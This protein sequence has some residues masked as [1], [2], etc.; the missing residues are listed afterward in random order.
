[1]R[2]D[3][4]S[5]IDSRLSSVR[6]AKKSLHRNSGLRSESILRAS[7][8]CF[9]NDDYEKVTIPLISKSIGVTHSLIYYY[10]KNKETL[11]QAAIL[12]ALYILMSRYRELLLE[13]KD[14]IILISDY[15]DV[16]VEMSDTLRSLV[17]IIFVNAG[18]SKIS[19]PKF[20]DSFIDDFYD[21]EKR[22]LSY[23]VE[24]GVTTGQFSCSNSREFA[25]FISRNIDG[26]YYG[27]FMPHGEPIPIA[28][29]YLKNIVLSLL[30]NDGLNDNARPIARSR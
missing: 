1:M 20:I 4:L 10:F 5:H 2:S 30:I 3:T 19:S 27:S 15:L 29:D 12:H 21:I 24:L 14:P 9:A 8:S 25:N 18:S 11:C 28:M 16:N 22:I 13:E 17:R 6:R 23:F 26:I 7:L